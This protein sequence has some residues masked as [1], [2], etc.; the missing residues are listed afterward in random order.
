MDKEVILFGRLVIEVEDGW[1][2][3][4]GCATHLDAH[5]PGLANVLAGL[6]G[7]KALEDGVLIRHGIDPRGVGDQ[8]GTPLFPTVIEGHAGNARVDLERNGVH[9]L[10]APLGDKVR[11]AGQ[12]GDILNN[13]AARRIADA[14][15][16]PGKLAHQY[17]R[18]A[19][20]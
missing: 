14:L 10:A 19:D 1:Q 4:A 13:G 20:K 7:M 3:L 9:V 11:S 6:L 12:I 15:E 8:D 17:Q 18:G 2:V 16:R 5:A